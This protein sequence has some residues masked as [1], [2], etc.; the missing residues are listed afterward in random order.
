[1]TTI[2]VKDDTWNKLNIL[3]EPGESMDDVIRKLIDLVNETRETH[4]SLNSSDLGSFSKLLDE[5]CSI[6][7]EEIETVVSGSKRGF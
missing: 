2:H 3:K 5:F 1:M 6:A 7:D 4:E